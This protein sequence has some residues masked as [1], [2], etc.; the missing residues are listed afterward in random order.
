MFQIYIRKREK[1][2]IRKTYSSPS[3]LHRT[4]HFWHFWRLNVWIFPSPKQFCNI[5]GVL[6]FNS[7]LTLSTWRWICQIPQ[8]KGSV[9]GYSPTSPPLQTPFA[10]SKFLGYPQ[11]LSDLATNQRFHNLLPVGFSYCWKSSQNSKQTLKFNSLLEGMIKGT[12]EQ[13]DKEIM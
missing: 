11:L 2:Y 1:K 5:H 6:Q 13:P 7:I 3:L 4:L 10:R 8:V 12:G 9:L